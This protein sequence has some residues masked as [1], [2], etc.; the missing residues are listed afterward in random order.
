MTKEKRKKKNEGVQEQPDIL[1]K[2]QVQE[3]IQLKKPSK[4]E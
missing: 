1:E 4:E 2:Q 3:E